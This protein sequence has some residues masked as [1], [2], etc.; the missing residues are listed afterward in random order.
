MPIWVSRGS[1]P[2]V[3]GSFG[4]ILGSFAG[5][6]VLGAFEIFSASY[7]SSLYKR[8]SCTC[9]HKLPPLFRP[10]GLFGRKKEQRIVKEG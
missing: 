6:I 7:V 10:E 4:S 2:G 8:L 9:D 5:G 3:I 1:A